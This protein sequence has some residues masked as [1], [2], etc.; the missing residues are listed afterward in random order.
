MTKIHGLV[1]GKAAAN[2]GF[3]P[4]PIIHCGNKHIDSN[5]K[6]SRWI[7]LR[8]DAVF[9][10]WIW[11][12]KPRSIGFGIQLIKIGI[13]RTM[14]CEYHGAIGGYLTNKYGYL[15][16]SPSKRV[17]QY[18][19]RSSHAGHLWA[20]KWLVIFWHPGVQSADFSMF[21]YA[22]SGM[23]HS[24]NQFPATN[25]PKWLNMLR[26]G[27]RHQI[28]DNQILGYKSIQAN[29]FCPQLFE[30]FWV[31]NSSFWSMQMSKSSYLR[32]AKSLALIQGSGAPSLVWLV[33]YVCEVP[34]WGPMC[35]TWFRNTSFPPPFLAQGDDTREPW[36]CHEEQK[37]SNSMGQ[38]TATE[39]QVVT[40]TIHLLAASLDTV[41]FI[42][43]DPKSG[44]HWFFF[45][46]KFWLANGIAR[47]S[48]QL[49]TCFKDF[50]WKQGAQNLSGPVG[51]RL[52]PFTLPSMI[53]H[54]RPTLAK[55]KSWQCHI[56]T[57]FL[58][59]GMIF[60]QKKS[61]RSIEIH[62]K[63]TEIHSPPVQSH[64]RSQRCRCCCPT[65][66]SHSGNGNSWV[67]AESSPRYGSSSSATSELGRYLKPPA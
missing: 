26:L 47:K 19:Y 29:P 46:R 57:S 41:L 5:H 25:L 33:L 66:P 50:I 16:P 24:R 48:H 32:A 58:C 14:L 1:R 31:S 2:H 30:G 55:F 4:F 9:G 43:L 35:A 65:L 59:S 45:A 28:S 53:P 51:N 23:G 52:F 3:L 21:R 8:S 64:S 38:R 11:G 56:I 18:E 62:R 42:V 17:Q 60:P 15:S 67:P 39:V 37:K 54:F 36:P 27:I 13:E 44:N 22:H 34:L 61:Q 20:H 10:V 49:C 7:Q 63:S 12:L 40:I 6:V